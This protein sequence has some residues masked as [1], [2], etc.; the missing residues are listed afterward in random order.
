MEIEEEEMTPEELL[1]EKAH[2]HVYETRLKGADEDA[3]R[4]WA[5]MMCPFP[6]ALLWGETFSDAQLRQYVTGMI[7]AEVN[8]MREE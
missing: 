8:R 1:W 4:K 5:A 2:E 6:K 3:L 7:E